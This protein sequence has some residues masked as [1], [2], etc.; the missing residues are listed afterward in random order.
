MRKFYLKKYK[1]FVML[2]FSLFML[3]ISTAYGKTDDERCKEF[4]KGFEVQTDNKDLKVDGKNINIVDG[5]PDFCS[6]NKLI[7]GV[8]DLLLAA[9]GSITIIFLMLG[10]FWFLTSAGN[11]E[12]AEKGKKTLTYSVVGLV[13]IIMS[14]VIVRIVGNTLRSDITT[15]SPVLTSPSP[16]PGSNPPLPPP[17]SS[18]GNAGELRVFEEWLSPEIPS[19][20]TIGRKYTIA[21]EFSEDRLQ[22][23]KT[24]C[25]QD[26]P[27]DSLLKATLN[28]QN[29]ALLGVFK[30]SGSLYRAEASM[31]NFQPKSSTNRVEAI[32]LKICSAGKNIAARNIFFEN[33]S[34]VSPRN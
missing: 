10:G 6:A 20:A 24:F 5:L 7:S 27:E 15:T 9:S 28:G 33:P 34:A 18:S 31:E 8:I 17:L 11:E 23:F 1:I 19:V 16:N 13:V 22:N 29:T 26:N 3:N 2:M 25:G 32:I 14:F 21:V 12:Q 30:K 4:R